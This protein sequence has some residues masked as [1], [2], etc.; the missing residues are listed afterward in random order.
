MILGG[1]KIIQFYHGK[2]VTKVM[3]TGVHTHSRNAYRWL[4]QYYVGDYK[5]DSLVQNGIV[6]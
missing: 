4:E 3:A 6:S 5:S 2:D 1:E